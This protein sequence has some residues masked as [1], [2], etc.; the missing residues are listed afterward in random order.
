MEIRYIVI[1]T[2]TNGD[3]FETAHKTLK[4]ANIRADMD[5]F[6]LADREKKTHHI[7]VSSTTE[8]DVRACD[9]FES[10]CEDA[11]DEGI[12]PNAADLWPEWLWIYAERGNIPAGA[13]D[14][15]GAQND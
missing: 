2:I 5:W 9:E 11:E 1:D 3:R 4:E 8:D 7:Y 15:K 13:F 12:D 10:W 6:H 14:S